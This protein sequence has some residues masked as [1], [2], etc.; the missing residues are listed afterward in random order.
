MNLLYYLYWVYCVV[1]ATVVMFVSFYFVHKLQNES[2]DLTRF[3]AW[4]KARFYKDWFILILSGVIGLMLK[5][6]N[7]FFIN[8]IPVLAYICFYGADLLFLYLLFSVYLAYKKE[9]HEEALVVKGPALRIFIVV[10][11]I[12]FLCEA[13][14]MRE[15]T[16]YISV[17]WLTYL[18]PY[19]IG[20]LPGMILPVLVL[21]AFCLT[22][23]RLA[24]RKRQDGDFYD[25]DETDSEEIAQ[26]TQADHAVSPDAQQTNEDEGE[27]NK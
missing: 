21:L 18:K 20:Y 6:C 16:Y 10:W 11:I 9:P 15:T 27:E 8:S 4:L 1:A 26:H 19:F 25:G 22:S 17:T 13:N 2:Y 5:V 7:I 12:T 3:C 14:M 24:F 23:P